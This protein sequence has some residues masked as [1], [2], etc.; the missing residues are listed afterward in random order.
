MEFKV[1]GPLEVTD[2]TEVKELGGPKQQAVLATLLLHRDRVI[3]KERLIELV[4][5]DR[6]PPDAM[7]TLRSYIS[8]LRQQI[9]PERHSRGDHRVLIAKKPGYLLHVEPSQLDSVQFEGLLDAGRVAL[10]EGDARGAMEA[11]G[12]GLALWRGAAFQDFTDCDPD[13]GTIDRLEEL[14]LIALEKLLEARLALG[15]HREVVAELR[16]LVVQDPLRE[17]PWAQLMLALYRSGQQAEALETYLA[18]RQ[19]LVEAGLDPGSALQQLEQRILQ[20]DPT[21]D[22]G[23]AR[24]AGH[25]RVVAIHQLPRDIPDLVGRD[26]LIDELGA[27]LERAGTSDPPATTLIDIV[28]QP[29]VGKTAL[30]IRVAHQLSKRFPDGELFVDL[31]GAEPQRLKPERVLEGFLRA[32]GVDGTA[33]PADLD[34][35]AAVYR[36]RLADR[37]MLVV[38]DNAA[39]EHQIRPLLPGGA[40]CA[41]LI[42]SRFNLAGLEA[43]KTVK[44]PA[45]EP[46]QGLRLLRM[47]VGEDAVRAEPQAARLIVEQCGRVPLAVRVV[48]ARLQGGS[49]GDLRRLAE[50]LEDERQRLDEM[51]VGD[52]EVRA[53]LA[54][55]YQNLDR[56][57]Q[58][59]LRLLGLV[60]APDFSTWVAAALLD[61][62]LTLAEQRV[63]RLISA[64]LVEVRIYEDWPRRFRLHDLPMVFA[65]ERLREE[66]PAGEQGEAQRR[67]LGC[68]LGLAKQADARLEF[69]GLCR[70]GDGNVWPVDAPGLIE[71]IERDPLGWLTAEHVALLYAIE[72]A[73]AA[74][75]HELTW[76]LASTVAAFFEVRAHWED[77]QRTHQW[78]FDA[79]QQAGEQRWVA[80]TRFGLGVAHRE[81]GE[82]RPAIE[83]LEQALTVLNR[84]Q[85]PRFEVLT[86]LNLGIIDRC[87]D[88][89]DQAIAR[90]DR[91]RAMLEH[92]DEPRW[93]AY[94]LREI[95]IILRYQ[96]RW[97]E[98]VELFDQALAIFERLAVRRWAAATLREIG[99]V[100]REQGNLTAALDCF[101]RSRAVFRELDDR[102]R[103][104]AALRSM[105]IVYHRQG[106]RGE[107]ERCHQMSLAM[108]EDLRDWHGAACT[109]V[110]LAELI[111]PQGRVNEARGHAEQ[112]LEVF[113]ARHDRRW[114]ARASRFLLEQPEE[115]RI[116]RVERSRPA[117]RLSGAS[118]QGARPPGHE[119]P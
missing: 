73:Y 87:Q 18:A 95:G 47:V 11:L 100:R 109:R 76:E 27:L 62:K 89:L 57:D 72:Q 46:G 119:G 77:W 15:E 4:W 101:E 106:H 71:E 1:L 51:A 54:L 112:A 65:R 110:C 98:A 36:D 80:Y 99:I 34:E 53:S 12:E 55:S 9:D 102:H 114:E 21:L 96:E 82:F 104:A 66:D 111:G 28:G 40:G 79:A 105:G 90:F 75:L 60:H 41:V 88:R 118:G 93:L 48:G 20:R 44:L 49:R 58:R 85:D 108:F 23:P 56:S 38:L 64:N 6:P 33:I 92:A 103:E 10:R 68:Y 17:G 19:H 94:T 83:H 25:R 31:R 84:L 22:W 7:G 59:L 78:A 117:A 43:I 113:R 45:L 39:N 86:L 30:A 24:D 3:S 52:R 91:C 81:K 35:R 26:Q 8:R 61:E 50:R 32:L 97:T 74:G 67:M 5:G 13:R 63:E 37:R 16:I 2:G 69:G 70:V 115:L 29:G 14:R 42:T 116:E 107:A